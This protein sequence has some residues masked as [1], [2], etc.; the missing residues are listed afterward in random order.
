HGR[1][2]HAGQRLKRSSGPCSV[3]RWDRGSP[4]IV[5]PRHA[6]LQSRPRPPP[7]RGLRSASCHRSVQFAPSKSQAL[8]VS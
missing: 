4:S 6:R 7:P 8:L 5:W 3:L 1:R 2:G